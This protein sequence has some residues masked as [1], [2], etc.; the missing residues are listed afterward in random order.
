M[1]PLY[2][3]GFVIGAVLIIWGLLKTEPVEK[4]KTVTNP[5]ED[6]KSDLVTMNVREREIAVKKGKQPCPEETA[7]QIFDD[8]IVLFGSDIATSINSIIQ[9]IINNRDIEPLIEFFKQFGDILDSNG[10]GLKIDLEN[11]EV[12]K[13]SRIDLDQKKLKLKM[14]KKERDITQRNIDRASSLTYGLNSS[15][16]LRYILDSIP[17]VKREVPTII[18]VTLEGIETMTEKVLTKMLNDLDKER[19]VTMNFNRNNIINHD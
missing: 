12:Y 17:G 11:D 3:V 13:S 5:L 2:I 10:Y 14:R 4:H 16:L 1:N 18:R 9:R 6:I 15:I 8:F 7:M 19:K